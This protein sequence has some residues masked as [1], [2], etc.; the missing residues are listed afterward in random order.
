MTRLFYK[1]EGKSQME[2]APEVDIQELAEFTERM[3]K[4]QRAETIRHAWYISLYESCGVKL[5]YSVDQYQYCTQYK[6]YPMKEVENADG[7]TREVVDYQA[8]REVDEHETL[9][10]LAL[11]TQH[12][13]DL[14]YAV[15]KDYSDKKYSHEILLAEDPEDKWN[16]VSVTYTVDREAVCR[17]VVTGTKHVEAVTIEAHDED[18]VEWQCDKI[19]FLGFDVSTSSASE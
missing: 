16:N 8:E 19:S 3:R 18:I 12:A 14:G 17:R 11:V 15:N 10:Y 7:T 6:P 9:R 4:K 1:R 2:L 5:P 13:T